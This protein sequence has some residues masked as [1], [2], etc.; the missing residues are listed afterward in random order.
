MSLDK[1]G[2]LRLVWL[3]P[4]PVV[5]NGRHLLVCEQLLAELKLKS[6]MFPFK[7]FTSPNNRFQNAQILF[8]RQMVLI[9]GLCHIFIDSLILGK[10]IVC[11]LVL[12]LVSSM[13]TVHRHCSV[14]ATKSITTRFL[15]MHCLPL[16]VQFHLVTASNHLQTGWQM[17]RSS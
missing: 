3:H 13:Q 15:V 6:V 1:I 8:W 17:F 10:K 11:K 14:L 16:C 5:C 4:S 2:P 12:K 9:S 7:I